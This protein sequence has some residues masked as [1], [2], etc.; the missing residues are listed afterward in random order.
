MLILHFWRVGH[1]WPTS[2]S[3][4]IATARKSWHFVALCCRLAQRPPQIASW[5]L[6][7]TCT[8]PRRSRCLSNARS[9]RWAE[10][11]ASRYSRP[12]HL[13]ARRR[14][15]SWTLHECHDDKP[16]SVPAKPV[17]RYSRYRRSLSSIDALA[18]EGAH[19]RLQEPDPTSPERNNWGSAKIHTK[20]DT[21]CG[22]N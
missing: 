3:W 22:S 20:K 13:P 7:A 15:C 17:L 9:A 8:Q 16:N 2:D 4:L 14:P 21:V 12:R 5:V 1:N 11:S 19:T 10:S 18:C 6:P